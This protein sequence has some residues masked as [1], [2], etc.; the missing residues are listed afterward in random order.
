M[1]ESNIKQYTANPKKPYRLTEAENRWLA[2][3]PIDYSDIPEIEDAFFERASRFVWPGTKVLVKTHIDADV[4]AFAQ[5]DGKKGYQTRLNAMLRM[6][7]NA[8]QKAEENAT[9]S[10]GLNR[11]PRPNDME[12]KSAG[13]TSFKKA[14]KKA[15]KKR[16]RRR[17]QSS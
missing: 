15:A 12:F 1:K 6:A 10:L 2:A 16:T 5:K 13:K 11:R 7:M 4:I 17:G 9:K 14:A 3:A 8:I